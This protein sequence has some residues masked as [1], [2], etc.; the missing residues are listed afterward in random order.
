MLTRLAALLCLVFVAAT[1][2]APSGSGV[3]IIGQVAGVSA[4][5]PAPASLSVSVVGT[6]I[7]TA[8]QADG[9]F[10]L[11]NV[12]AGT[13]SLRFTGRQTDAAVTLRNL[14]EGQQVQLVVSI[15]GS[16]ASIESEERSSAG[17]DQVELQG[18]IASI[19]AANRLL[20]INDITVSVPE[21]A[22][23]RRL[24]ETVPFDELEVDERVA[25]TGHTQGVMVVASEVR[26]KTDEVARPASTA[27]GANRKTQLSGTLGAPP[28]GTCPALAFT[29]N[30]TMVV[31]SSTTSFSG[32]SCADLTTGSHVEV[33]GTP[34]S[35]GV[36]AMQVA[37]SDRQT[38]Q[39][40]GDTAVKGTLNDEPTG[41]C[42]LVSFTIGATA[43][44]TTDATQFQ[45]GACTD[46]AA[47]VMVEV[48][49]K[50]TGSSMVAK[51]VSIER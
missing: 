27:R 6:N 23:I 15:S 11:A 33:T 17:G 9:R 13:T 1:A 38:A 50:P 4:T 22:T 35:S 3:T 47:G 42:P 14:T 7:S 21:S 25:I 18:A 41:T 2:A 31:T 39:A 5:G 40:G 48:R 49:G 26:I 32:G 29:V 16:S 34:R 46:L 37:L 36:V 51:Q 10:I 8:V 19:D 20:V 45:G 12:P 30:G 43:I 28:T 44:S 24:D